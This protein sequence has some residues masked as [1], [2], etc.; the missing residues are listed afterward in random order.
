[1]TSLLF[2][3]QILSLKAFFVVVIAAMIWCSC[4]FIV[5]V[6]ADIV[7]LLIEFVV[8]VKGLRFLKNWVPAV[9]VDNCGSFVLLFFGVL[10][11]LSYFSLAL[12]CMVVVVLFAIS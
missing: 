2:H 5:V 7:L 8:A 12:G 6:V 11:S 3:H 10:F 9:L 1:M 4:W